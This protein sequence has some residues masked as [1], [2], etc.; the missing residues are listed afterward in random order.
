MIYSTLEVW[1]GKGRFQTYTVWWACEK[2][3]AFW[4]SIHREITG[5]WRISLNFIPKSGLLH[6]YL[7][8]KGYILVS[9]LLFAAK[10]LIA[11]KW[12][13]EEITLLYELQHKCQH[14]LLMSKLTGISKG[15]DHLVT[16]VINLEKVWRNFIKY[17]KQVRPQD[18][19]VTDV[20]TILLW[21]LCME[22]W[23]ETGFVWNIY[24]VI[25]WGFIY[26]VF[27]ILFSM[28]N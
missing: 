7:G 27:Y 6:L 1:K 28:L 12:R 23:F 9:D 18:N 14:I 3:Q 24:S 13:S 15:R 22:T 2:L 19:T 16:A 17:W 20:L 8:K 21:G 5:K 4:K 10:A 25:H 11:Q 26:P